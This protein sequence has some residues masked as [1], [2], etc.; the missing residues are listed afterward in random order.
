MQ[1]YGEDTKSILK[2]FS[3]DNKVAKFFGL[4]GKEVNFSKVIHSIKNYG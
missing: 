1:E 4:N 2:K 3:E